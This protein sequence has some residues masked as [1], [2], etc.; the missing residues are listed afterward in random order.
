MLAFNCNK[1]SATLHSC[2]YHNIH[3]KIHTLNPIVLVMKA[4]KLNKAARFINVT[5]TLTSV[6]Q[7]STIILLKN[8]AL[9]ILYILIIC[10][11][12]TVLKTKPHKVPRC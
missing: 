7:L 12:K 6:F 11:N 3:L 4:K 5:V 8:Y 9:S 2:I 10:L 1:E